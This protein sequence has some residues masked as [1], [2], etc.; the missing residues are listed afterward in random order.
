MGHEAALPLNA[1]KSSISWIDR[2]ARQ[3]K[4]WR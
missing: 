2:L 3:S 1:G 4:R